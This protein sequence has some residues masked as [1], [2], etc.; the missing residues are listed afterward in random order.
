MLTGMA[1]AD[2]VIS[3]G[4][5]RPQAS[6]RAN[7]VMAALSMWFV[8]GLFLDA[9]AH[10]TFPQLETFFTP[11]HAVFY[12]GFT[13]TAGWVAW[14]V[15]QQVRRGR[16]GLEAVPLGYGM[17][18]VALPVFALSGLIDAVWH[19][20]F[21]IE[22]STDIFF[23]PSHLGLIASM[24]V[25]LT[26]P[27]RSAW[28]DPDLP[29]RPPLSALLPAVLTLAFATSLVLLFVTYGNAI[30][31]SAEAV[32]RSFSSIEGS[33][34]GASMIAA[35]IVLT[36]AILLAPVLLLAR[37]WH[38]PFGSATLVYGMAALISWILASLETASGPLAIVAA[39]LGVDLL[40]RFLRPTGGR[41][42]AFWVF[43]AGAGLLTWALFLAV[44]SGVAGRV[45]AVAELWT[46]M[47]IVAGLLGWLL[48]AL[49]LPDAVT[50]PRPTGPVA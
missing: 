43:A 17:T 46:G 18:I 50:D 11:W 41:R 33:P 20:A 35:R 45:P 44:A 24:V 30:F 42:T 37:R 12:S 48:G 34:G 22:T 40:A 3:S 13:A 31:F 15:Y 49:M 39:G 38:V 28:T 27:L 4:Q 23:S 25:I 5:K 36:N 9:F 29:A 14:I 32:V 16:R 21:G 7:M 47:P 1:L 8:V 2:L 26:S 19:T 6:R 10:A